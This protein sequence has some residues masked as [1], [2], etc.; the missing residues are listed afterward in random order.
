MQAVVDFFPEKEAE[1]EHG[2][3]RLGQ[4]GRDRRAFHTQSQEKDQ[5]RIQDDIGAGAD[6]DGRHA[7]S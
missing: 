4:D 5:N 1:D 3:K 7:D 2:G 6:D